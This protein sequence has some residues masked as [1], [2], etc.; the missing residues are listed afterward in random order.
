LS[1]YRIASPFGPKRDEVTRKWRKLHNEELNGLYSSRLIVP[2]DKIE[3]NEIDGACGAFGEEERRIQGI[4]GR[5]LRERARLGDP[6]I[7]GRII[8]RWFFRKW[9]VEWFEL[10]HDRDRWWAVVNA[11]MNLRVPYNAENFLN[12]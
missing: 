6:G 10:A 7:D 2:C 8:L 11:V 9:G 1:W 12:S 3:N 5:N 4:G